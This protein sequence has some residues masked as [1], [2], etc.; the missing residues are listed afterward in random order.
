MESS[1]LPAQPG[2][3]A[4]GHEHLVEFY[5]TE[6]F[7]VASVADYV[8]PALLG[9]DAAIV[10]ATPEHREAFADALATHGV[11]VEEAAREGRYLAIDAAGLLSMFMLDGAP[12]R[13]RFQGVVTPLI[14]RAATGEREVRVYGEMVA[15]LWLAGDVT[16]TIALEDLWNELAGICEFSLFCG[17]PI[18]SFD[19][20]SRALF[21]HICGQHSSVRSTRAMSDLDSV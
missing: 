10:V 3:A 8:A 12:D 2:C 5:E 18:S 17:Y 4:C 11:D 21:A 9:E 16:S 1:D 6:E 20:Q 7:L 15:L 14:A 19:V 13:D